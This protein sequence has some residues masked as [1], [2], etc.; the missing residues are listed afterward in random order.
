MVLM[1]AGAELLKTG[2]MIVLASMKHST[3]NV[4]GKRK[5]QD[6]ADGLSLLAVQS[7]AAVLQLCSSTNELQTVMASFAPDTAS[8][9]GA[10][11]KQS[12]TLLGVR[13]MHSRME[14][15]CVMMLCSC[16][17]IFTLSHI[18]KYCFQESVM[19]HC[20]TLRRACTT[21][22]SCYCVW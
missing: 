9:T 20:K 11:L 3:R 21:C 4:G 1:W 16:N 13:D 6:P 15:F 10:G 14:N 12:T 18:V 22:G 17:C 8:A 2:Q 19:L 5:E 7:M